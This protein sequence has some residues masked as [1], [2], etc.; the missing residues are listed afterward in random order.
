MSILDEIKRAIAR[1]LAR[2]AARKTEQQ[3]QG[4][5]REARGMVAG[6]RD[7]ARHNP[8]GFGVLAILGAGLLWLS[9]RRKKFD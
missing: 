4:M 7:L 8:L 1:A 2:L 5:A 9:L 6:G 3:V